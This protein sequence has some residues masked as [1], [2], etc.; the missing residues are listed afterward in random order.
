M[1]SILLDA[2]ILIYLVDPAADYDNLRDLTSGKTVH[3]ADITK[4]EVL[5]YHLITVSEAKSLEQLIL[6]AQRVALS[7]EVVQSAIGLRQARRMS[8]GDAL[9]AASAIMADLELW[10]HNTED[11]RNIPGLKLFDPL[12]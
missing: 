4:L 10:T 9:T 11:Y 6:S 7:G 3:I 8:L 2:N 12:A 1:S 5:G